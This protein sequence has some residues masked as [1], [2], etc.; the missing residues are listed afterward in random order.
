MNKFK[1]EA[2]IKRD[3]CPDHLYYNIRLTNKLDTKLLVNYQE[4]RLQPIINDN[5]SNY[6]VAVARFRF[7]NNLPIFIFQNNTYSV[8]LTGTDGIDH[9]VFCYNILNGVNLLQML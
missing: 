7:P 5:L 8:T 3:C 1:S 2:D 6:E 9:T 4:T